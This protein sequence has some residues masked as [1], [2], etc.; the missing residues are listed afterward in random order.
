MTGFQGFGARTLRFLEE[1]EAHNERDWFNANKSRYESD[2]LSPAL[3]FIAAMGPHLEEISEHF[4]AIPK[5]V[6]GSLMRVHR[7][8][9]FARGKP[10]KTN[11]GIQFRH[12]LGKDVHAPGF[13]VHLDK[14][15]CFLAAGLWRP[16]KRALDD[17]RQAIVDRPALW[18]K[19]RDDER[20]QATFS[21]GGSA[22]KRPP[23]GW[24]AEHPNVEDLKRKDHI[25]SC[26]MAP[27][28]AGRADF[29]DATA[30]KFAATGPYMRFLCGALGLAF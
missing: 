4:A 22:L 29:V 8:A 9:R 13:Y 20:F 11:I 21:L 30:A 24:P 26:S 7:D 12:E 25:A 1:L 17:I 3:G 15:E 10:Y 28:E 16:E 2:V 5:R 27:E 19:A 18:R 14:R 23:R 6:G